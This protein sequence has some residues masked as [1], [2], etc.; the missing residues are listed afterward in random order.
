MAV[1]AISIEPIQ[2]LGGAVSFPV[3]SIIEE[4]AQT[5]F[6]GTPV[7]VNAT[8]GGVQAYG[9]TTTGILGVIAGFAAEQASNLPTT[10]VGAPQGFTPVLGPGSRIGTYASNPN[11]PAA[12]IQPPGVPISDGRVRFWVAADTIVFVGMVGNAGAAA[13]TA[14]TLVGKQYGLSIDT[15]NLWYVDLSKVTAGSNVLVTVVQLD[16][17]DPVGRNGGRVWFTVNNSAS[18][19]LS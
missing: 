4:A 7:T 14:N 2:N 3:R 12:T 8:D 5:F 6:E 18:Q 11:Q 19:I 1:G 9:G 15:N 10:G 16:P 17:R 13:P